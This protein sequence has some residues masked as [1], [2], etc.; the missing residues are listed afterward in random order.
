[1]LAANPRDLASL[2]G[3][4]RAA[5]A[6]GD[7]NAAL[8]STR[9]P[10]RF[11]R[12]TA[13]SR[14]GL[15][16]ALV[17]M[18]QPRTALKL[19]D[20]AVALGV[21]AGEIA[22]DRGLAHDLNGDNRSAQAD[23]T[24]AL[25]TGQDDETQRRLALSMA[26]SGDRDGALAMLEP[27]LRRND[28]GAIRARA[29]VLALTGDQAGA[30]RAVQTAMPG[31]Q[32]AVMANFLGR[33]EKLNP[34]QKALAVN[35]GYFPRTAARTA[36]RNCSPMRAPRR[37]RSRRR[38]RAH[39]RPTG[40]RDTP[41]IPAGPPLGQRSP[42]ADATRPA[43]GRARS[44]AVEV[45]PPPTSSPRRS[46]AGPPVAGGSVARRPLPAALR[47][48]GDATVAQCRGASLPP[49]RSRGVNPTAAARPAAAGAAKP[50]P[51]RAPA[52][53]A[54]SCRAPARPRC[55]G[56]SPPAVLA[57]RPTAARC[58]GVAP[59][60]ALPP[61]IPAPVDAALRPRPQ[62]RPPPASAAR[63]RPAITGAVA[64][65]GIASPV[66]RR[67]RARCVVA[68]AAA[69]RRRRAGG[70]PSAPRSPVPTTIA[71]R[72]SARVVYPG[73]RASRR[74]AGD[75][76]QACALHHCGSD[77]FGRARPEADAS[78]SRA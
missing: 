73:G 2:T 18:E 70:L 57:R 32:A 9:A 77:A 11:P 50:A 69:L 7:A 63:R 33:L 4:G 10:R 30:A 3:A 61:A 54:R 45:A 13:G 67:R 66:G 28:G 19:F 6:V 56:R 48:A 75:G 60:A 36:P 58:P 35:F 74:G 49:R 21:P 38:L 26:I 1:M 51:R 34:A 39:P 43:A 37:R 44:P 55:R 27:L 52:S 65:A 22:A 15:A 62:H 5:L 25:R 59:A 23:Y 72:R 14:P 40:A 76:S 71:D 47:R 16:T 20:E 29:F 24:L 46:R 8:G 68:A 41:L 12:A 64:A 78:R 42:R 17:Q 31:P 53:G